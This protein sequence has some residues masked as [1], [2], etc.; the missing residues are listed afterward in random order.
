MAT[1]SG[2]TPVNPDKSDWLHDQAELPRPPVRGT[3]DYA[4]MLLPIALGLAFTAA[5]V[6]LAFQARASWDSHRDWVVPATIPLLALGGVAFGYLVARRAWL[7]ANPAIGLLLL[8]CAFTALNMWRGA[9]T[10]GSDGLRDALSIIQGV[11]LGLT[12]TAAVAAA[13]FVEWTR[14][15]HPAPPSG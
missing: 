13:I 12:V 11:T 14:P 6:A 10:E 7:A 5:L 4:G 9:E 3:R 1:W 2:P 15:T 8:V